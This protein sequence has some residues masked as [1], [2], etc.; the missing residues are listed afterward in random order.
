MG[1]YDMSVMIGQASRGES[2]IVDQIAGNQT[3]RELNKSP[4]Y[5]GGWTLL[6]RPRDRE[7]AERMATAC[8]AGVSNP[9]IGY[10]QLQRNTL[11]YC[12]MAAGWNLAQIEEPCETDCSAFMA[13]CAE[14]A[15]VKMDSAYVA[16][17]APATFQMRQRWMQTGAFDALKDAAYL[18]NDRKL[19]RGDVLVN[20]L[21]HTCMVLSD[22]PDAWPSSVIIV[23]GVE[24]PISRI[25]EAGRNY[26]QLRE[27]AAILGDGFPYDIS[28]IGSTAVLT[29]K[30]KN[31]ETSEQNI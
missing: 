7:V 1:E 26:F 4:W 24:H 9:R 18:R 15:G 5:D 10:D 19:R 6:L 8:E 11:R 27:L 16:C 17:N 25:L 13:V 31:D 21:T 29:R 22:G 2:G 30:E 14:A 12:A 3:G 20:E 28:N 23:D